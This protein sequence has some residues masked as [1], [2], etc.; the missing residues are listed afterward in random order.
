MGAPGRMPGAR[1]GPPR[2]PAGLAER[3]GAPGRVGAAVRPPCPGGG[4]MGRPDRPR[5]GPGGGGMGLPECPLGATSG[6]GRGGGGRRTVGGAAPAGPAVPA[7]GGAP[8]P[9]PRA[10]SPSGGTARAAGASGTA[11]GRGGRPAPVEVTT[12]RGSAGAAGGR[13]RR[14]GAGGGGGGCGGGGGAAAG[15]AGEGASTVCSATGASVGAATSTGS[16]GADVAAG[17]SAF[18]PLTD[19]LGSS[20]CSSRTRPSRRALRRTRS[21]WASSTPEEWVFTPMPNP[22]HRSRAS[23]FVRPSSFASSWTRIFPAKV[24]CQSFGMKP[25]PMHGGSIFAH[26]RARHRSLRLA[27]PVLRRSSGRPS[28]GRPVCRFRAGS[29][30]LRYPSTTTA[31]PRPW[32]SR[33]L[34][35]PGRTPCAWRPGRRRPS[36]GTARPLDRG[37]AGPPAARRRRCAPPARA[38]QTARR[39]GIRCRCAGV[40]PGA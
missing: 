18:E 17:A 12:R 11:T 3:P 1:L 7:P 36:L 37:G 4:G 8:G 38:G 22:T 34:A 2:P 13:T 26:T 23:L 28:G 25:V 30:P 24:L 10:P 21:A 27:G 35:G 5:G 15:G 6:E 9:G 14:A 31:R 29:P 20:G 40:S 16:S 32:R 19:F 39:V 33:V